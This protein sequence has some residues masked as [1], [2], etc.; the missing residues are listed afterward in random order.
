M[1]D[2]YKQTLIEAIQ[3]LQDFQSELFTKTINIEMAGDLKDVHA[4]FEPGDTFEFEMSHIESSNDPNVQRLTELL[5]TIENIIDTT[6][7]L[8]NIKEEEL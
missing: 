5:N 2:N 4:T 1:D 6:A 8:N 3:F 7:N